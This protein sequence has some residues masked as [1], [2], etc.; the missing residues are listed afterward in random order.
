MT[1]L[2][3]FNLDKQAPSRNV[4]QQGPDLALLIV[5]SYVKILGPASTSSEYL[6]KPEISSL[7]SHLH[8]TKLFSVQF[9]LHTVMRLNLPKILPLL[10][11]PPR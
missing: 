7:S 2:R 1:L 6:F 10:Y 4:V 9:I 11:Q 8:T 5:L 3:K